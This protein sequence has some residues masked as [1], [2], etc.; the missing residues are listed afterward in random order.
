M[1]QQLTQ[2]VQPV[3]QLGKTLTEQARKQDVRQ[4]GTHHAG[5][6][7]AAGVLGTTPAHPVKAHSGGRAVPGGSVPHQQPQ[8]L[9][10]FQ[11]G[12]VRVGAISSTVALPLGV[13]SA[14]TVVEETVTTA[15]ATSG[16]SMVPPVGPLAMARAASEDDEMHS[17]VAAGSNSADVVSVVEAMS[18]P[19]VGEN[20]RLEEPPDKALTL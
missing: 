15:T 10:P 7:G 4:Q 3:Q 20:D 17:H 8:V 12:G 16:M 11:Q 9:R 14:S 2:L 1:I 18:A 13:Q 6:L 19:V 5:A